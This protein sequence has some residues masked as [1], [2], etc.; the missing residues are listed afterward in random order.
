MI[1]S[2]NLET[3]LNIALKDVKENRHLYLTLEHLLLSII[4][5]EEGREIIFNAGGNLEAINRNL[6]EHLNDIEKSLLTDYA[7][8][9]TVSLQ[10]TLQRSFFHLQSAE[11]KELEIGD[12]II[13]IYSEEES[14]AK[15]ILENNG[16]SQMDVLDF[17]SHG[18]S[19]INES[20]KDDEYYS[21]D[22][23]EFPSDIKPSEKRSG[24]II[25]R[26]AIDMT[27]L[28]QEGKYD[29]LIGREEELKR[30]V[31]ILC[32]RQKNNP[33]HVGEPGVG[34][35]ALTEGLAQ[36]IV[37]GK[38]PDKLKNY[39]IFSLDIGGILAGTKY[40][41]EFEERLKNLLRA[42]KKIDRSI[43]FIDEIHTIVGAGAVSGGSM[44]AS[45]ILKPFLSKG[46]LRCIGSTT[47]QEYKQYFEKDRALSRRFQKVEVIE[48]S[49]EDTLK[50]IN[51]IKD[52]YEEYHNIKYS[53]ASI[54]A[55]AELSARYIND[56]HLPD[57]AIDVLDEVGAY[58]TLYRPNRHT[59]SVKDVEALI[60]R[61]ARVPVKNINVADT[62]NLEN[63]F[64]NISKFVF[65]QDGAIK[66]IT[67]AV[68]RHRAG[69][70][71]PEKPIGSFLFI[72]PTGVGK[73]ELCKTLAKELG[74]S[75]I[76]FDMSE[77]MEKHTISRLLGSPPGYVGYEQGAM[78][79]DSIQK[80]PHSVLLLDE[81]EKA[82]PDIFNAL[83]QIM[84][85]ATITDN[86]GRKADF[87]NVILI[88]TSN[89]GS[90]EMSSYK[91]GFNGSLDGKMQTG[92]PI[93]AL[94]NIF[95]PEFR[96]RLD[97]IVVFNRLSD[98]AIKKIV[99]KFLSEL[100]SQLKEKKIALSTT[101]AVVDYLAKKG[102]DPIF[103]ARPM[104]RIIHEEIKYKI[105]DILISEKT[106]KRS[107][108]IV[109]LLEDKP[110]VKLIGKE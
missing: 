1:I 105:V 69:L 2:K 50:I 44:D 51:G 84:D 77:Y 18:I 12:V 89:A 76:R 4:K 3:A 36:L 41:G 100:E 107:K 42:I 52:R 61:M 73:T 10:R 103:G 24:S 80:N 87:R 38:V 90:S 95:S 27:S 78:L 79:T 55:I 71:H 5:T 91:I 32:R 14:Y 64:D 33:I 88:M 23:E 20:D 46:D 15:Y 7:P 17:I 40:R 21:E 47:F 53:D 82:H 35:T 34:K 11:K 19:K 108:L 104:A 48:P 6:Q 39:K 49:V 13:S 26:F 16:V 25:E 9:E 63:L 57:K 92:D 31:E 22:T 72:G 60:S 28:A 59:V 101:E 96:N 54:R 65:G 109:D 68:K 70:G 30:T 67:N 62:E 86:T 94:K 93:N 81:I 83:L 106:Q 37:E 99:K 98:D 43:I 8:I 58:V 102:Y 110:T 75:L 29:K 56:R 74:V 97:E 66:S 85:H 45:N